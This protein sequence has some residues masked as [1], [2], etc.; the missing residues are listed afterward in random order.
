MGSKFKKTAS[1]HTTEAE[2]GMHAF[3]IVGYTLQKGVGV[4]KF[5]RSA[6]FTVGGSDWS[7]RFYPDGFSENN[8]ECASVYLELM[9]KTTVRAS[10]RLSLINLT[11]WLPEN[12]HS[13][14]TAQ[15]FSSSNRFST[16]MNSRLCHRPQ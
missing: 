1:R 3:E 4:G 2:T 12:L 5:I 9:S 11:T 8:S 13:L 15:V 16:V 14:T 6:T 7:I 10:Y